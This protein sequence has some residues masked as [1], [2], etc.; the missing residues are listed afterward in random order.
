M[1]TPYSSGMIGAPRRPTAR[2]RFAPDRWR[3]VVTLGVPPAG[4]DPVLFGDYQQL[5]RFFYLFLFRDSLAWAM[6]VVAADGMAFLDRLWQEWSPGHDAAEVL[7]R[8]KESLRHPDNLAAAISYY[9]DSAMVARPG[10]VVASVAEGQ[11]AGRR[12]GRPR[13]CTCTAAP[14]VASAPNSSV[15]PSGCCLSAP[16]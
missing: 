3:R 12:V 11:A 14:T 15:A 10:E 6:E 7:A 9:R 13:R 16:G 4:L 8:A 2:L 1:A 5:K